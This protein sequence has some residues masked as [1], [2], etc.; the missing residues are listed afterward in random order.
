MRADFVTWSRP[1]R[2]CSQEVLE[3]FCKTVRDDYPGGRGHYY[4]RSAA[5]P[6]SR[7]R[8][9]L[10]PICMRA[11]LG[12]DKTNESHW[13]DLCDGPC[14]Y[15]YI[16][17]SWKNVI[18]VRRTSWSGLTIPTGTTELQDMQATIPVQRFHLM[19]LQLS[20]DLR[21]CQ[22]LYSS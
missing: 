19:L 18:A 20:P 17:V 10:Y 6:P 3:T 2:F 5:Y 1:G 15:N 21:T 11:T 12:R 7:R 9:M 8:L 4:P 13:P 22:T 14:I 16:S